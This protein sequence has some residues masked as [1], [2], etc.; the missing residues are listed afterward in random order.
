MHISE[1]GKLLKDSLLS[2]KPS[3][4]G[5]RAEFIT[6]SYKQF[7]GEAE[8]IKRAK[9]LDNILN[10]KT[11]YINEGEL[12]VGNLSK[13]PKCADVFPE[14]STKWILNE[15]EE[16]EKRD[17]D[18]FQIDAETKDILK[19]ML[20][21]W[22]GRSTQDKVVNQLNENSHLAHKEFVYVLTSLGSGLGHIAVDYERGIKY[23]L[24][25][26]INSAKE[27]RDRL[28]FD[29]VD[30]IN[31]SN[32]YNAVI[33]VCEAAINFAKRFSTYAVELA[34]K[35]KNEKRKRE[36][37]EIS[38]VCEKI[39]EYPAETFHE[40]LQAF[41][42]IHLILQ[43]E[44]NGHSISPGRFDQY[45]YPYYIND[46]SKDIITREYAQELMECLWI[47]FNEI[48]K[49]RDKV[50]SKAFGGYPMFQNLIL[51][52]VDKDGNDAI[53][54]L[55]YLCMDLTKELKL[56][57]PSLSVRWKLGAS[58]K[59]MRKS[60][61][62][63]K[64]GIGMPAF[65]N[66]EVIVPMLMNLGCSLEEARNYAEI[67][68]VEPQSPG[69]TEG[70][71]SGGFL[72]LCKV[73]EITLNNGKNP[74]TGTKLGLQTGENFS[75]FENFY[76]AY[77]KQLGF[78]IRLQA[79]AD[80]LIDYI[81]SKY[82]P[83]PFVSCFVDDCIC[84]G[85][86]VREG[87][88]RYNFTSPNAVG[89]A[90]TADALAVIKTAVFEEKTLAYS[91]LKKIMNDNYI[92]SEELR[93]KFL[94]DYP[95]FGNDED[96]VDFIAK[97]IA[98]YFCNE[99]KKIKNIRGGYFQ[100]GLQSISTHALLVNTIGATP[101]GRKMEMLLAD[102]GCS[103]AQGR[104]KSGPTAVI[105]SVS[106]LD[107]YRASGGTL[108]NIKLHPSLLENEEGIGKMVSFIETYFQMKG[109][110]VQFNVVNTELL[111]NA[112]KNPDN[113]SDLVVRVAGFS[114]YFTSVDTILQEDIIRRTEQVS[115]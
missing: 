98:T 103:P 85:K 87:G 69:K 24:R 89:L 7:E 65:F 4:S 92:D 31:K 33:I 8:I 3:I 10:N 90:N 63:V 35:E 84:S 48:I 18:V 77:Q 19:E 26:I 80:N 2:Y 108:L 30:D 25:N 105:R 55:T 75:D 16:F 99:F 1:R 43:I 104:D 52:G 20:S 29:S 42:F 67:G 57:Q 61:D 22:V 56:P 113:Y 41:W 54:E 79:E 34:G 38:R 17:S 83:T 72:N 14:F 64:T 5:E 76:Q 86:D 59:F 11:I 62:V 53:N 44:S 78:F 93:L 112:Q 95:K 66:D 50:G 101:D 39:P 28:S 81:H 46:V 102:G 45:I 58:E 115:F 9:T 37:I 71:Y 91:Q 13:K 96:A 23:G 60:I 51:G 47:K 88:A 12:I 114:V 68:C 94:N 109:Q 32:F 6:M 40:A 21:Y 15:M 27:Y 70:F 106:K 110:H 107:H 97:D 36:L 73:L 74:L 49:L 100:P 111:R 82:V